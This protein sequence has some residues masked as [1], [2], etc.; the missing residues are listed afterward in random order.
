VRKILFLLPNLKS[1]GAERVITTVI[2]NIDQQRFKVTLAVVDMSEPDLI[3]ELPNYIELIDFK[4]KRV[5]AALPSIRRLIVDTLP[6]VV[7]STVSHLNLAIAI[8]RL[9]LPDG[10]KYIARETNILSASLQGSKIVPILEWAYKTFYKNID[11]IICQSLHM[12]D[13]LVSHFGIAQDKTVLINNPVD[14]KR[15]SILQAKDIPSRQASQKSKIK[16]LA[17]GRLSHEKGMDLLIE[18]MATTSRTDVYLTIIGD[19]PLREELKEAINERDLNQRVDLVGM[20]KNPYPYFSEA[21][22]LVVPSRREGFPNVVLEG[23][24]FR[25]PIIYTPVP[26]VREIL[27]EVEGCIE[28]PEISAAGLRWGIENL[29]ISDLPPEDSVARYGVDRIVKQYEEILG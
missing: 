19:G 27:L 17:V 7:I 12:R 23:L 28:C 14:T 11:V 25:L 6:A 20:I 21:D 2:R 10:V 5:L 29:D 1:G 3:N 16:L 13:D 4:K 26:S 8:A 18:A 9:T 24:V 22:A 15:I